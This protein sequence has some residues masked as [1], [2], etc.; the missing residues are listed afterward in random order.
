MTTTDTTDTKN[1]DMWKKLLE[2]NVWAMTLILA[3]VLE[4]FSSAIVAL[5][6]TSRHVDTKAWAAV[7]I[8]VLVFGLLLATTVGILVLHVRFGAEYNYWYVV[9]DNVL[10]T[11]PLYIAVRF[12]GAS[13]AFGAI[14]TGPVHLN[15]SMFRIG[16]ALIAL[17]LAFLFTRDLIVLPKIKDELSLPPRFAVGALHFLAVLLF[18]SLAITPNSVVYVAVLGTM[19][20]GFFFAGMAA[21]TVIQNRFAPAH[22]KEA[23]PEGSL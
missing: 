8:M 11:V 1:K 16:A 15:E 10:I 17:A 23:L 22:P 4:S 2:I 5:D 6:G 14:S 20:L 13:I 19:G 3:L 21:I 7:F 9:L 18:L 12:I